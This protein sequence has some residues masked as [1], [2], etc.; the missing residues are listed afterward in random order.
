M[1]YLK[2]IVIALLFL[3]AGESF[4]Q[5]EPLQYIINSETTMEDL[6]NIK[7][8]LMEHGAMFNMYDLEFT[9]NGTVSKISIKVDFGDGFKGTASR[10][11]FSDLKRIIIYRSYTKGAESICVGDC[12]EHLKTETNAF[13]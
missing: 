3:S 2:H 6:V 7:M 4:A 10:D 13:E 8:D 11:D 9:E 5:K 12:P 1:K